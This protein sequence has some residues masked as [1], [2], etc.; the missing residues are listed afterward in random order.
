MTQEVLFRF[1]YYTLKF[2]KYCT[3]LSKWRLAVAHGLKE[4]IFITRTT[5]LRSPITETFGGKIFVILLAFN[6]PLATPMA[7]EIGQNSSPMVL[8]KI[9]SEKFYL[10]CIILDNFRMAYIHRN[11][12]QILYCTHFASFVLY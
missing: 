5:G 4:V 6:S 2:D 11:F 10:L 12:F 8:A 1:T 3:T 9:A 7:Q